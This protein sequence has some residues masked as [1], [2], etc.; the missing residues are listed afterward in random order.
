[1]QEIH[2]NS[3]DDKSNYF[4]YLKEIDLPDIKSIL[5]KILKKIGFVSTYSIQ[6]ILNFLYIRLESFDDVVTGKEFSFS[7]LLEKYDISNK[8]LV[9]VTYNLEYMI[10]VNSKDLC[11]YFNY[12]WSIGDDIILFD[13]S[14]EWIIFINSNGNISYLKVWSFMYLLKRFVQRNCF[15][16]S[17]PK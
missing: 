8:E 16:R 1:M 2:K 9:Y 5:S 11:Q 10:Q 13:D 15:F 14:Y 4:E 7:E 3:G 17:N 12:I 6:N